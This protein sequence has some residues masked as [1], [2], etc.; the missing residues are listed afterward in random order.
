MFWTLVTVGGLGAVGCG[1]WFF[2]EEEQ[3]KFSI[4]IFVVCVVLF[5]SAWFTASGEIYGKQFFA[6]TVKSNW[7]VVDNS[8][9]KT[10]RH[11][12]LKKSYVKDSSQSDGWQFTD[13]NGN[14]CYVSGDA[15]V[16]QINQP[17]ADFLENYKTLYNVPADQIA[18]K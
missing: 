12:V 10:L 9:G 3:R 15:F 1:I 16:M 14:L 4:P 13:I 17:L 8:G 6:G 7:F 11:W 5:I 18:L 2:T